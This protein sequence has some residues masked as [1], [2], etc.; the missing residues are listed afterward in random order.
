MK[1]LRVNTKLLNDTKNIYSALIYAYLQGAK[2]DGRQITPDGYFMCTNEEINENL[3]GFTRYQQSTGLKLLQ[4][5]GLID[6]KLMGFPAFRFIKLMDVKK[7][8]KKFEAPKFEFSED[9]IEVPDLNEILDTNNNT[10]TYQDK[11]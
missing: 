6:V 7:E 8:P 9:F 3:A 10:D 1:E 5:L 2:E 4:E 11:E